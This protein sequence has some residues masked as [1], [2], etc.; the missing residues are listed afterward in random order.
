MFDVIKRSSVWDELSGN[1]RLQWML[2]GIALILVVSVSKS[3]FDVIDERRFEAMKTHA[4]IERMIEA[5]NQPVSESVVRETE[6]SLLELHS[7]IPSVS[8]ASIAEAEALAAATLLI[9]TTIAR[10]R[11]RMVGTE[12]LV[13]EG[14][15][16]WQ[17][18]VKIDGG[19]HELNLIKL[20]EFFDEE[21][22]QTRLYSFD[23]QPDAKGVVS[24]V[25]DYL[26]QQG[27]V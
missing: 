27:T 25:V 18:R 7:K 24:L 20:L 14:K 1:M 3:L 15:T 10:P 23:F 12:T 11:A 16:Y 6:A 5:A 2:V 19:L 8:T 17:V 26:Y 22:P 4:M 21:L 13:F 9:N